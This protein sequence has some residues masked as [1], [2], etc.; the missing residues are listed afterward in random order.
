MYPYFSFFWRMWRA[1]RAPELGLFDRSETT[2]RIGLS[3]IDPWM[4]LNNGRTLTLYDLGRVPHYQQ[5]G[6]SK[7]IIDAGYFIAVTGSTVRYR[8]RVRPFSKVVMKTQ[9]LGWD[10]K[11]SYSEQSMWLGDT[12]ANHLLIR[13]A[14]GRR[15]KGLVAPSVVAEEIGV[16]PVSPIMDDWV[17]Q[18]IEHEKARP[19]P[20]MVD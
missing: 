12:C 19:W 15:D 6:L 11:F 17:M 5:T 3:D 1:D 16:D 4:E 7:K 13:S 18:W 8:T 14:F 2:I 9:L 20:P 10:D